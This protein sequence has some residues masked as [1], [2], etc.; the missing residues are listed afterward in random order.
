MH[1]SIIVARIFAVAEKYIIFALELCDHM[2]NWRIV[3]SK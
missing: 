1:F 2:A 3:Q